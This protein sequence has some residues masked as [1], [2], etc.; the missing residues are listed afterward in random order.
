MSCRPATGSEWNPVI[1]IHLPPINKQNKQYIVS[2]KVIWGLARWLSGER[3]LPSAPM[4]WGSSLQ[5]PHNGERTNFQKLSSDLHMYSKSKK[6]KIR[7]YKEHSAIKHIN[8]SYRE[9]GFNSWNPTQQLTTILTP[10]LSRDL[11]PLIHQSGAFTNMQA[12][13]PHEIKHIFKNT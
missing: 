3:H 6:T 9:P 8:C 12:K 1:N 13:Q 5:E 7:Q 11:T 4:I 2:L 10:L